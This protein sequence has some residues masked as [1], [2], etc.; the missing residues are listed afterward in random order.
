MQSQLK[1]HLLK[2]YPHQFPTVTVFCREN[3]QLLPERRA[4]YQIDK[5][6]CMPEEIQRCFKTRGG[7]WHVDVVAFADF[8]A[9]ERPILEGAA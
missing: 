4:R 7:R 6:L 5:L 2:R 1:Q 8:M 9:D 3:P